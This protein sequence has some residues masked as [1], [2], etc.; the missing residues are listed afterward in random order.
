M[1]PRY[2]SSFFHREVG[3]CFRDWL[4][5]FRVSKAI[6]LMAAKDDSVL[7]IALGVGF[8]SLR[9]FERAFKKQ[10]GLTPLQFKM[11]V[12]PKSPRQQGLSPNSQNLSQNSKHVA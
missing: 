7:E 6:E 4:A 9:T 11:S 5:R 2:F 3:L 1:E 10:T 12:R 8:S